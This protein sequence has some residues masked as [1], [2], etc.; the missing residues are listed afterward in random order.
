MDAVIV[1][2]GKNKPGDPLYPYTGDG[3]KSLLDICGK[4]M[5]QW[6]LDALNNVPNLNQVVVVGLPAQV[7][8]ACSH[9]L[10]I[11][12]DQGGM[13]Q[14]IRAG[15]NILLAQ[16][17][18][19]EHCL[20]I[21]ADVPMLTAEMVSW[22]IERVQETD[23][24][25]Y[26]GVIERRVMEGRFPNSRRT[27]V[28]LKDGEYCGGD[29]NAIRKRIVAS[30]NPLIDRLSEAR[31][32]PIQEARLMGLDTLLLLLLH[33]LTIKQVI[34]KIGRRLGMKGRALMVPY[35][36]MGMDVDKPFQLEIVRNELCRQ[37][38]Q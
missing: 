9:R 2:G 27:Y 25:L 6:V 10:T 16:N 34:K 28:G 8:L 29:A 1:A 17:P 32:N 19:E 23:H 13:L 30:Q 33:Q 18:A 14:N 20:I 7:N 4:P 26:Y 24:D 15:A 38:V 37:D 21:S 22:L 35:A 5:V 12:E 11:L 31:K 36:E 3:Y